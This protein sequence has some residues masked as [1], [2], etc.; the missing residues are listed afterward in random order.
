MSQ[1]VGDSVWP[2]RALGVG[3]FAIIL[4]SCG[5]PPLPPLVDAMDGGYRVSGTVSGMWD[6]GQLELRLEATGLEEPITAVVGGN[7]VFEFDAEL[8]NGAD[9]TVT[10]VTQ[11]TAHDCTATPSAGTVIDV[12]V[13][14][15]EVSCTGP[16]VDVTFSAPIAFE[17]ASDVL[18]Y[19]AAVSPL[20]QRTRLTVT[21]PDATR[22]GIN[23]VFAWDS[24]EPTSPFALD[25]AGTTFRVLVE[26]AEV[27]RTFDIRVSR[28]A[29]LEQVAFVKASN[30]GIE[31]RFG[32]SVATDGDL[33]AISATQEDSNASQIDG[34]QGDAG[35][36][37]FGAVY[38]FRRDPESG[39]AQEAYIKPTNPG[40][41][42]NFGFS[43]ALSGDTLVVGAPNEDSDATGINGDQTDA[44]APFADA[45]A[46]YVFR[47]AASGWQQE[48]YLKASNTGSGD[49]FGFSVDVSGD[50]V[51]IGAFEE[52]SA[53]TGV[54][55]SQSSNAAVGA[56]AAYVFRRTGTTWSQEAYLKASNTEAGDLFGHQV[57]IAGDTVVCGAFAEDSSASGVGGN[58]SDNSAATAGA[59]YVFRRT[60]T[61]W[62]QEAY[63][64]A[65]NTVA[66][67]SFGTALDVDGDVI[68]VGASDEGGGAAYSGAAYVFRRTTETWA[69]EQYLKAS[70][71]GGGDGFGR[72]VAV[73][74][75]IV[76]VG[77]PSEDGGA[78][79]VNGDTDDESRPNAG[80]TYVF[81]FSGGS[82]SQVSYVKPGTPD[83]GDEF[84]TDVAL[85]TEGLVIGAPFEA[86]PSTGING[87]D[88]ANTAEASGAGF[89][90]W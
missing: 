35:S 33:V 28:S 9:Y 88:Q 78:G 14:N 79:G 66:Y 18:E 25:L 50:A 74:G 55:G 15:V 11:P 29:I 53:A 40:S 27:S 46:A 49:R 82:W 1:L 4:Q 10:V 89:V 80:A 67:L 62:A 61:V 73:R 56:G 36:G 8:D 5:F 22:I 81:A 86:S 54:N 21:A 37:N 6:G 7:G 64:K 87:D 38:V 47:R 77:A 90:F 23:D 19:D 24:G 30:T 12:H 44:P 65:S 43:L 13:D 52:D 63:L 68:I 60:G 84:A 57:A 76:A 71:I 83:S 17:F 51:V 3:C 31:D 42:D 72:A 34:P 32:S 20:I 45:G 16:A 39:W 59:A 26:V 69:Q 70:N 85:S 41:Q 2:V 48:A 75:D 58:Q